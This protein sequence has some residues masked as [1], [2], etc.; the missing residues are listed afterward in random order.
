MNDSTKSHGSRTA[1]PLTA[2]DGASL[3]ESINHM[4]GGVDDDAASVQ[5]DA[6]EVN[7]TQE[8]E[9]EI[10]QVKRMAQADTTRVNRSRLVVTIV[11]LITAFCVTYTTF[12][13]LKKEEQDNFETAVSRK[14]EPT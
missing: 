14:Q 2:R 1:H 3:R 12:R 9:L 11:L 10:E 4:H 13:L 5:D 7:L 8:E 6:P